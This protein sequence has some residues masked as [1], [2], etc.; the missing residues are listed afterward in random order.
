MGN[1]KISEVDRFTYLGSI[2]SEDGGYLEDIKTRIT[3]AQDVFHSCGFS[4]LTVCT[5]RKRSLQT[6]IRIL[7]G[8]LR[9]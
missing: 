7:E 4:Q 1:K 2:I 5:H 9:T 6:Q 8:T 3:R